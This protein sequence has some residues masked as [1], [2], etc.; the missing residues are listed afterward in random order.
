MA[1]NLFDLEG[2]VALVTGGNSGIGRALAMALREAGDSVALQLD[3]TD[4][5]SVER[6]V[7]KVTGTVDGGY[8]ASDGLERG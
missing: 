8:L 7:N 5:A 3:V 4:E 1:G 2:R 6:A